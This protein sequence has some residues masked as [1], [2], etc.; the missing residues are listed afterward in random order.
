MICLGSVV[1]CKTSRWA[2]NFFAISRAASI[3]ELPTFASLNGAR[4]DAYVIFTSAKKHRFE[5][6]IGG[7]LFKLTE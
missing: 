1:T 7:F 3:A 2:E 4:I 6:D 5:G